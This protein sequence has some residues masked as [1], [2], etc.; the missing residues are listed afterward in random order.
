M[1]VLAVDLLAGER[2]NPLQLPL[3]RR[4]RRDGHLDAEL[5]G[6]LDRL[7][8]RLG[9]VGGEPRAVAL[10]RA[11]AA[12]LLR[13]L[14]AGDLEAVALDRGLE[15][16]LVPGRDV[17]MV[18]TSA[19]AVGE[20]ARAGGA[21]ADGKGGGQGGEGPVDSHAPGLPRPRKPLNMRCHP[22]DH[23]GVRSIGAMA[24]GADDWRR[25]GQED[26]LAGLAF[27]CAD[28]AEENAGEGYTNVRAGDEP[29]GRHWVCRECFEDFRPEFG[30]Q[31][32]ESD[33]GAWPYDT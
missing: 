17:A 23:R 28:P 3:H 2:G 26:R 4:R 16:L 22:P 20:R 27:T 9:V 15:V 24:P 12:A 19:A 18:M 6:E 10:H 30:W 33:P 14:A 32:V 13:E 21:D 8:E 11:G 25:M 7:G 31:V 1:G 29:S 5:V